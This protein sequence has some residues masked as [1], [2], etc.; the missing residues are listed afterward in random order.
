MR[1]SDTK[2]GCFRKSILSKANINSEIGNKYGRNIIFSGFRILIYNIFTLSI[3]AV[4]DRT[5]KCLKIFK[6]CPEKRPAA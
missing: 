5:E 4:N 3:G 6:Q 2:F 1:G